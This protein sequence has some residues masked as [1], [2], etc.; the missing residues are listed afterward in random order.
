MTSGRLCRAGVQYRFRR[1]ARAAGWCWPNECP[2]LEQGQ[3]C[4]RSGTAGG[5]KQY[6]EA[7]VGMTDEMST[8]AHELRDIVGIT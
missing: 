5:G 4:G 2:W 7:A 1:L 8:I 3:R 6:A